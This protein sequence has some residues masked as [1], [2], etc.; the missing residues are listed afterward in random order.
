[1]VPISSD[2]TFYLVGKSSDSVH[3]TRPFVLL[4]NHGRDYVFGHRNVS[5]IRLPFPSLV[6]HSPLLSIILS[7]IQLLLDSFP[8]LLP[9]SH[10]KDYIHA[11][12]RKGILELIHETECFEHI[13]LDPTIFPT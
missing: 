12:K 9:R 13:Q 1:M 6:S 11:L 8:I 5:W 2:P 10:S 4:Y 7:S 3:P